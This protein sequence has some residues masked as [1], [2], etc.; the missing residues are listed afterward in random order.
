MGFQV[1]ETAQP[2][3]QEIKSA[4]TR[5]SLVQAAV[6]VISE[7]GYASATTSLIAQ[8]AGVSRGAFQHHFKSKNEIIVEILNEMR[9]QV[10]LGF[11]FEALV[12]RP[13]AERVD[14]ILEHYYHVYG[15]RLHAASIQIW[16]GAWSDDE[17]K[18][19]IKS[20][21]NMMENQIVRVWRE[22]FPELKVD[23]DRLMAIR[24]VIIG[25]IRGST[26]HEMW[27]NRKV[28]WKNDLAVLRE[29]MVLLLTSHDLADQRVGVSD[30]T[31]GR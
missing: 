28:E 14:S 8:R 1:L 22:T 12:D 31:S 5:R 17:L 20:G 25:T 29:I 11:D 27:S 4:A 18:H 3:W 16:L 23:D 10:N 30:A 26:M 2:Q 13:F 19:D 6:E 15:S 7:I 24:N 21:L 9:E